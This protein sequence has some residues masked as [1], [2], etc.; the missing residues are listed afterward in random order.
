M[1]CK[2]FNIRVVLAAPGCVQSKIIGKHEDFELTPNSIYGAFVHNIRQYLGMVKHHA[3]PTDIFAEGLVSKIVRAN[4]PR[5]TSTGG[6]TVMHL[7]D[8]L[9]RGLFLAVVWRMFSTRP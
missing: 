6:L 2:P 3:I 9:P 5:Y 8:Y 7:F 1:E 4:P